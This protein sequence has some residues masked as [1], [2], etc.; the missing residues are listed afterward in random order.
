MNSEVC[1][2]VVVFQYI[3]DFVY[4]KFAVNR[5]RYFNQYKSINLIDKCGKCIDK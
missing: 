5:Q 1:F 4:R 3:N 2:D